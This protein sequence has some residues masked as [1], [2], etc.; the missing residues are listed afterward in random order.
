M[1]Q[2]WN[3]KQSLRRS[4]YVSAIACALFGLP[5]GQ[6]ATITVNNKNDSGP[7]SLRQALADAHNEDTI[8]FD[9]SLNGQTITLASGE[10]VVNKNV[11]INGPGPNNLAVD[12]NHASRVFHVSEGASAGISGLSITNGFASG[13]YG[14]GIY[15]DHS[16]LS[17]I[18][19][20][21]SGNSANDAGGIYND[22][23]SGGSAT[24][25]VLN[26]TLSGNG[27]PVAGGIYNYGFDGSATLTI[28]NSTLCGNSAYIGGSIYN[29]GVS[30]SATLTINNSTLSDNSA[31]NGGGI[32]N[33]GLAGSA[34]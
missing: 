23:A 1:K 9:S 3:F 29:Y 10:L 7:G 12:A 31:T 6:A 13:L 2:T 18:N 15:N 34:A 27:A 17:V 28:N 22:G 19:C 26:C 20:A 8:N 4:L 24:L 16:T 21:L 25:Y 14:G 11:S 5:T 33:Y 30:G 32:Y